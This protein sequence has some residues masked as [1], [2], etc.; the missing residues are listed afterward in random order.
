MYETVY[1]LF[2]GHR[3]VIVNIQNQDIYF[4]KVSKYHNVHWCINCQFE[5]LIRHTTSYCVLH[6]VVKACDTWL[7][8]ISFC[9]FALDLYKDKSENKYKI[10]NDKPLKMFYISSA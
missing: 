10:K 4:I 1:R 2:N 5:E 3:Y 7:Q 6:C 8:F 9:K